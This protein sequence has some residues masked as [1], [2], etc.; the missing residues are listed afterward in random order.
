M[1]RPMRGTTYEQDPR[2]KDKDT[3]LL[4]STNWPLEYSLSVDIKKVNLE[5]IQSW[6]TKQTTEILGVEDEILDNL[7]M[8]SLEDPELCPKKLQILITGFLEK[9]TQKFILKLW[10]LL[11]SAQTNPLGVPQQIINERR[12]ELLKK[13]RELEKIHDN[14][15]GHS[16]KN[17]KKHQE[18]R[19]SRSSSSEE[20]KKYKI[21]S[22]SR[23]DESRNFKK[24]KNH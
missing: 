18:K 20:E 16:L 6:I 24:Y 22:R 17:I 11:L 10:R 5:A 14:L 4:S 8:S 21:K 9:D 12:Q 23:S 19:D 2:Y 7:I 13:K 15:K 1:S 3:K